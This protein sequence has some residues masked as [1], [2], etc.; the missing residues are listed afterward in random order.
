M[1]EQLKERENSTGTAERTEWDELSDVDFVGET[2]D[3]PE[4]AILES[5]IKDKIESNSKIKKAFARVIIAAA[6]ALALVGGAYNA[7]KEHKTAQDVKSSA[8]T[9]FKW[10]EPQIIE[11]ENCVAGL[12]DFFEGRSDEL[13]WTQNI[14]LSGEDESIVVTD[15]NINDLDLDKFYGF[16]SRVNI[17]WQEDRGDVYTVIDEDGDGHWDQA[18]QFSPQTGDSQSIQLAGTMYDRYDQERSPK[19]FPTEDG[20][21]DNI[22]GGSSS[23]YG[24]A[25]ERSYAGPRPEAPPAPTVNKLSSSDI[26]ALFAK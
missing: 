6:A 7:V 15:E 16:A 21:E 22:T 2:Q 13:T 17:S 4:R 9:E 14:E 25:T 19:P 18:A 26:E 24:Q 5:E 8:E 3:L 12:E 20:S 11:P 10:P 23:T 1:S